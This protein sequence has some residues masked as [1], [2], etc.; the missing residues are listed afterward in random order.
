[1]VLDVSEA[2]TYS[3]TGNELIVTQECLTQMNMMIIG[4]AGTLCVLSIV[5]V[6]LLTCILCCQR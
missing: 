2:V 4:L 5:Q 1:M 6:M 3:T